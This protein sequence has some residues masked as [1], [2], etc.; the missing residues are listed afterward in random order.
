[1]NK[2]APIMVGSFV[3]LPGVLSDEKIAALLAYT[4]AQKEQFRDS[5][6][7]DGLSNKIDT[8]VRQA[9]SCPQFRKDK[10]AFCLDL[11]KVA[12]GSFKKIGL[13]PFTIDEY[14]IEL[15]AH[16]HG[17]FFKR[18]CDTL[19]Q[20][21]AAESPMARVVSVI[22]YF[23]RQPCAFTGGQLRIYSLLN[24]DFIDI[25]PSHNKLVMFPAIVPHEVLPVNCPS[26][27]FEDARFAINIWLNKRK[28][29]VSA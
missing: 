2:E 29:S 26:Q 23:H 18:H 11:I 27:Q 12:I 16:G 20:Q 1:M 24:E 6:V 8:A 3:E 22:Y 14:E 10:S 28:N 9:Q 7:K 15:V 25:E 17:A 21:S 5:V 13:K 19:T 4:L